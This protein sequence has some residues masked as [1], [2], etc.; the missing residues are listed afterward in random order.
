MR[1]GS[2]TT[3][4]DD[5]EDDA[6]LLKPVKGQGAQ[7]E[8]AFLRSIAAAPENQRAAAVRQL[9]QEDLEGFAAAVGHALAR[10]A[11]SPRRETRH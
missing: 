5:G 10:G 7:S 11:G 1:R 3:D 6:A 8:R 9:L 4:Q 2:T